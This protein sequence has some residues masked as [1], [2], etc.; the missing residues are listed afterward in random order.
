MKRFF[1]LCLALCL[2]LCGCVAAPE[3][4]DP[5][6]PSTTEFSENTI[7]VCDDSALDKSDGATNADSSLIIG[8][9]Q[10]SLPDG[11]TIYSEVS[12]SYGLI[13]DDENCVIGLYSFDVSSL[14]EDSVKKLL[15][16]LHNKFLLEDEFRYD[17]SDLNYKI[18]GFS[19]IVD[20]YADISNMD[21]P[22]INMNTTFTDSYYSYTLTFVCNSG[23][24]KIADFSSAFGEM[25]AYSEYIG[26]TPRFDYV[27]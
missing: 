20:F 7:P 9:I 16:T 21:S 10:F 22:T 23:S 24:G 11:F 5:S 1:L 19:V 4:T 2:I 6:T 26:D 13:S 15:P 14:T 12:N 27:Q 25:L 8:N 17:E 18:A 3:D